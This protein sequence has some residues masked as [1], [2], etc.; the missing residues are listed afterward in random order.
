MK[1]KNKIFIFL[2]II[3]SL[4]SLITLSCFEVSAAETSDF[5]VNDSSSIKEDFK[6]MNLN[7]DLY[8]AEAHEVYTYD[9]DVVIAV[10]ESYEHMSNDIKLYVYSYN[11]YKLQT[12]EKTTAI[13][14]N[15]EYNLVL[16]KLDSDSKISKYETLES[17]ENSINAF[18]K[19]SV[20]K[21][22]GFSQVLDAEFSNYEDSVK[23]N[24]D[25]ILPISA[26]KF[27]D[28]YY[29]NLVSWRDLAP[30]LSGAVYSADANKS[31]HW[32]L[33]DTPTEIDEIKEITIDYTYREVYSRGPAY[34]SFT[35]ALNFVYNEPDI[36]FSIEETKR[37]TIY[38]TDYFTIDYRN[39]GGSLPQINRTS[40]L[41][42]QFKSDFDNL[43]LS[44]IQFRNGKDYYDWAVCFDL[45]NNTYETTYH[46]GDLDLGLATWEDYEFTGHKV[47]V[48]EATMLSCVY[49]KDGVIYHALAMQ[50]SE[51]VDGGDFTI[52]D[53]CE[54]KEALNG[55]C[56]IDKKDLLNLLVRSVPVILV[57]LVIIK[58]IGFVRKKLFSKN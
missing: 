50:R 47:D 11:P 16:R 17:V 27:M 19:Y 49:E 23:F 51:T 7:Y 29:S 31:Q 54:I 44:D 25:T 24:Y 46:S 1:N 37:V 22:N 48:T 42:S 13:I 36:E 58:F 32:Y 28:V 4:L 45:Y 57:V 26:S 52:D 43:G 18:R 56:K 5:K 39:W 9:K 34:K 15:N 12:K 8:Y 10:F 20:S 53:K 6:H 30:I 38:S 40:D 2:T 14:N 3:L 35:N 55:E 21:F 41:V 33:F